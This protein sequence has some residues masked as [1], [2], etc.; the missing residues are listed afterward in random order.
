MEIENQTMTTDTDAAGN[1]YI[2]ELDSTHTQ[3]LADGTQIT[4]E[5]TTTADPDDPTQVESFMT[6][7]E[8]APDGTETVTEVVMNEEGTFIVEEESALEEA[9]EAMFDVEI[10]DELTPYTPGESSGDA[11]ANDFQSDSEMQEQ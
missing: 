4:A 9:V 2:A 11:T 1:E 10:A 5:I 6:Y 3:T 7:T 8:T